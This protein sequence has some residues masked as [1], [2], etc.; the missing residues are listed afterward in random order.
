MIC[1]LCPLEGEKETRYFETFNTG[2]VIGGDM[3]IDREFIG[4]AELNT[5]TLEVHVFE[6]V[7]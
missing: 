3:G 1:V 6:R 2:V 4:T 5:G 7:N